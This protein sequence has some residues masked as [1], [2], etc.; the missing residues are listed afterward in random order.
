MSEERTNI[1]KLYKEFYKSMIDKDTNTLNKILS[2]DYY[3]VHMTGYTQP[4][5]E[6]LSEINNERMRYFS[7]KEE[8]VKIMM[9]AD[10]AAV[11]SRNLVDARI[12]GSRHTWP[13]Q[14]VLHL[15][16][17]ESQWIIVDTIASTY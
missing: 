4:K 17:H 7:A 5:K 8:D 15:E 10:Q 2:D 6:W 11:H 12:Y 9:D 14:L 13:L 1:L 16:K 3:L